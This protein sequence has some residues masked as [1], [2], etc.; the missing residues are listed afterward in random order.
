M[1]KESAMP[2]SKKFDT[3]S[4]GVFR[5][6]H[7]TSDDLDWEEKESIP[8]KYMIELSASGYSENDRY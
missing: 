5:R 8:E 3:L 4:Q 7:N 6:L 2:V 1:S